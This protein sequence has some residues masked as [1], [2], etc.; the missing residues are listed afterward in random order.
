MATITWN[1]LTGTTATPGAIARWLNKSSLTAGDGGDADIILDEAMS[2]I[3]TRLRH[4]R[5][6]TPPAAG[7]M[8]TG[9]DADRI[10]VPADMAEPDFFMIAGVVSGNL[11]RQELVQ[12]APNEIYRGWS[13]DGT[14]VRVPNIPYSYSF[15][16]SYIQLDNQPDLAYPYV[17]AYYQHIATLSSSNT[18]NFLTRDYQR[19]LRVT[20]MMVG[21]EYVKENAQ[22]TY[23]R[24]YWAQQAEN[25]LRFVQSDSDSAR[26]GQRMEAR[27]ESGP[28]TGYGAYR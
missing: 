24:T 10:A 7:T 12:R 16:Q 22:G 20:C 8:T 3:D 19:L 9:T 5:M 23:D 4:W 17:L 2:W 14:G 13:Y 27:F 18:E 26:R 6:L 28:T 15:N 21:V 25:E 11:Y 1:M